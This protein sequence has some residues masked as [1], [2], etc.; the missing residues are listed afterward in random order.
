MPSSSRH[1]PLLSE[2]ARRQRVARY[3]KT[4]EKTIEKLHAATGAEVL[5]VVQ[6]HGNDTPD[7]VRSGLRVSKCLP[8]HVAARAARTASE[9]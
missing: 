6:R 8:I 7:V 4:A 5:L 9:P 2:N 3:L 1:G